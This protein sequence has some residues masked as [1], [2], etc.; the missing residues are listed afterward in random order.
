MHER[1][2]DW[3][4]GQRCQSTRLTNR[5]P[6]ANVPT[7]IKYSTSSFINT[8]TAKLFILA[9]EMSYQILP[10]QVRCQVHHINL[11]TQVRQQTNFLFF[12]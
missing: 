7:C 8:Y 6:I 3:G 1:K 2:L 5:S 9:P 4:K 10:A 11:L 12:F